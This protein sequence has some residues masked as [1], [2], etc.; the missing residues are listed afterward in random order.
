MVR[1]DNSYVG[2]S[3][4]QIKR[5]VRERRRLMEKLR[6][7][8]NLI[9]S[10]CLDEELLGEEDEDGLSSSL[11]AI[12]TR[13]RRYEGAIGKPG[14]TQS[15]FSEEGLVEDDEHDYRGGGEEEEEVKELRIGQNYSL[16]DA[17][18]GLKWK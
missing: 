6:R 15:S 17:F 2:I 4:S 16:R 10:G 3:R 7:F 11:S 12:K 8:P 5:G 14:E 1:V 13:V 9:G 18:G